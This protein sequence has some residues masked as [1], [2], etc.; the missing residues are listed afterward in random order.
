[1]ATE[2]ARTTEEL[3]FYPQQ[4][5]ETFLF[6]KS[7]APSPGSTQP[8]IQFFSPRREANAHL[9][10]VAK[11]GMRGAIPPSHA[12]LHGEMI[13]HGEGYNVQITEMTVYFEKKT[14]KD[15]KLMKSIS[16][17]YNLPMPWREITDKKRIQILG[18]PKREKSDGISLQNL[19]GTNRKASLSRTTAIEATWL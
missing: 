4:G 14:E 13:K 10:L 9:R 15:V 12:C 16:R 8:P 3:S 1:M 6:F 7:T 19:E 18:K 17:R 5:Q 11:L 2:R